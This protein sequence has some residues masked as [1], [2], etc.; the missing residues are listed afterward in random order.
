MRKPSVLVVLPYGFNERM[1]NFIEFVVSRMLAQNGWRVIGIAR[2]EQGLPQN[3]TVRDIEVHRYKSTL[4]GL[5]L[6][7]KIFLRDRPDIVHVHT[8]RNNRVG[9]FVSILSKLSATPL[10]FTESGLLHDHYLVADRD[11][12]LQKPIAYNN[13]VRRFADIFTSGQVLFRFKSY[14]FHFALSHADAVIFHSHHNLPIAEKLGLKNAHLLPQILDESR[15]SDSAHSAHKEEAA[16]AIAGIK[17]PCALFVGQIKMRK[18]WDILLRSIPHV[19]KEIIHTFIM[20]TS[21]SARETEDVIAL[22]DELKVRGRVL[23]LGQISNAL[24]RLAFE[25]STLVA[26]PS[27]YEGFGLVPLEAFE[28]K[29]PV[30]ASRV[31]AMTDF[32]VN[33]KNSYLVPPK[34]PIALAKGVVELARDEELQNR[35]IA[36]GL[37]TLEEMRS[38]ANRKKWLEFYNA[39]RTRL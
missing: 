13:F 12:P 9:I 36:G 21:S 23:F 8:L 35:L 32:L 39:L 34:D 19:P 18:G 17:E 30:I 25:K 14:L 33:G 2:S 31:E 6:V 28:M 11:D 37:A 3:H 20:V 15:W 4:S 10:A 29:R 26:V 7:L 38:D 24:L 5:F 22:I 1:V 16:S 27:R